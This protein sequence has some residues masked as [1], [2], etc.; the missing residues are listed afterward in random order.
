MTLPHDPTDDDYDE[1][2]SGNVIHADFWR[3]RLITHTVP[4][5]N[6]KYREQVKKCLSNVL[7]CMQ[8]H[9]EL[10]AHRD[11][12]LIVWDEFRGC[13]VFTRMPPWTRESRH[14]GADRSVT[15]TDAARMVDWLEREQAMTVSRDLVEQA[16]RIVAE[17]KSVHPVRAYLDS[18]RWDG[19]QRLPRWLTDYCGA[20]ASTYTSE[21]GKR[22]MISAIAR[23]LD[24]GCVADNVLI[25]Q[26]PQGLGKS[27]LLRAL[28]PDP[29]WYTETSTQ[30]GTK[31]CYQALS[32]HWLVVLDELDSLQKSEVTKAKSF[33]TS[34]QDVYRP[35]YG[36][37]VKHHKRQCVF[38][39]TTNDETP[40][41]D[42]SGNRR[43]W[44][45]PARSM[46][47]DAIVRDRDQLWAEAK[48]RYESSEVHHIDTPELRALC[49]G[50]QADRVA[51]DDWTDLIAAWLS[52]PDHVDPRGVRTLDVLT[53]ALRLEPRDATRTHAMRASACLREIGYSERVQLREDGVRTWRYRKPAP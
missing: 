49:E 11:G 37:L 20:E 26:G 53:G 52:H 23:V 16:Y 27:R 12:P 29:D 22:W 14:T 39:G 34:V 10:G 28:C 17:T 31:D 21:V 8:Y 35:P 48:S 3:S 42:R 5:G 4:L 9:P 2:P 40:F 50:E 25:L 30:L 1:G 43:F 19:K 45:V 36:R 32:G 47:V 38:A 15:E 41:V 44:P 13:L 18:I 6:G 7:T 33:L 24:P 46:H 51:H